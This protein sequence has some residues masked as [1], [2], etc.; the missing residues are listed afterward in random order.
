[1]ND[2]WTESYNELVKMKETHGTCND[3]IHFEA[4]PRLRAW[5]AFQR[6]RYKVGRLS[7]ERVAKL[8]DVGLN[9]EAPLTRKRTK[10]AVRAVDSATNDCKAGAESP[11]TRN[12][13]TSASNKTAWITTAATAS[14]APATTE[15][16]AELPVISGKDMS[17]SNK[18]RSITAAASTTHTATDAAA[19]LPVISDKDLSASSKIRSITAAASMTPTPS[20]S[21]PPHATSATTARTSKTPYSLQCKFL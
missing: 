4:N 13:C 21:S 12:R 9:F 18:I 19:E 15:A 2:A 8:Q 16:A 10:N 11:V 14:S 6:S 17:A 7:D 1:M 20:P 3:P 5:A